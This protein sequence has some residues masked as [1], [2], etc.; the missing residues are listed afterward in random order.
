MPDLRDRAVERRQ[1]TPG[2][3]QPHPIRTLWDE[4]VSLLLRTYPPTRQV[5]ADPDRHAP[6]PIMYRQCHTCLYWPGRPLTHADSLSLLH[7]IAVSAVAYR[8]DYDAHQ[9]R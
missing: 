4:P 6:I 9:P 3:H 8:Q 1:P 2:W 5:A 7:Q